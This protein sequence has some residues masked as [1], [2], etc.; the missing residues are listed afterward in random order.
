VAASPSTNGNGD[1][2]AVNK[3]AARRRLRQLNFPISSTAVPPLAAVPP[4]PTAPPTPVPVSTPSSPLLPVAS[5]PPTDHSSPA[6]TAMRSVIAR[7]TP[8]PR[9]GEAERRKSPKRMRSRRDRAEDVADRWQPGSPH[10]SLRRHS[11]SRRNHSPNSNRSCSRSR[12]GS[13]RA[14]SRQRSQSRQ[15]SYRNTPEHTLPRRRP[16]S[17]QGDDGHRSASHR[18]RDDSRPREHRE[19]ANSSR[20]VGSQGAGNEGGA[21]LLRAA[22]AQIAAPIASSPPFRAVS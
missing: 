13:R 4:T 6:P 16:H 18:P 15:R 20:R 11:H 1:Q 7:A 5:S 17:P 2:A 19:G 12:S 21:Q 22:L 10:D 3:P 8:P 9:A 14:H